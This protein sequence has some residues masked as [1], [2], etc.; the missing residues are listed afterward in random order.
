MIT[1]RWSAIL[2]ILYDVR[3]K[4]RSQE[5]MATETAKDRRARWFRDARGEVPAYDRPP[6]PPQPEL[7]KQQALQIYNVSGTPAFLDGYKDQIAQY[8]AE[9]SQTIPATK[10]VPVNELIEQAGSVCGK[11]LQR[12]A[13]DVDPSWTEEQKFAVL[14][15]IAIALTSGFKDTYR[16]HFEVNKNNEIIG[17]IHPHQQRQIECDAFLKKKQAEKWRPSA[18]EVGYGGKKRKTR[19]S[20]KKSKKTL[21]R[22]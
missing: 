18:V 2:Y 5:I 8:M 21:R 17:L 12:A 22:K 11:E 15:G 13:R 10:R 7:T 6:G 3:N 14:Y 9:Y 1:Y 19:K 20:S 16:T 4:I